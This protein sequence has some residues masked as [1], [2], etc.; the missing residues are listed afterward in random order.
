MTLSAA[1]L[2]QCITDEACRILLADDA[3]LELLAR[4]R[5]EVLGR[6]ALDF[7]APGDRAINHLL[8]QRLER[9][10]RAFTITKRYVRSDGTLQWVSNHVSAFCDGSGT[11]R[12]VAT[13]QPQRAASAAT[14]AVA[15]ARQEALALIRTM[16]AAK[17]AFGED[18]IGSPALEIL[19]HLH[20]AE[21]EGRSL[22][23]H[24]LARLIRQS[25]AAT[26]R[27]A[28]VLGQ[29]HLAEP[30]RDGPLD[31]AMPLRIAA[32][33]QRLMETV[34]GTARAA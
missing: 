27:W 3:Y 23:P 12:F 21:L 10:G 13:C 26:L 29:R 32:D 14:G 15:R 17:H 7:T 1:P 5:D 25:D 31:S 19:L 22:T 18:L 34:A 20:I 30:E 2:A 6:S 16:G 24:C 28:R 9:Q 33:A 11:R 4:R 8:L